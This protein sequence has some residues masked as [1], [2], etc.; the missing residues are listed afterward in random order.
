MI[1]S[2]LKRGDV[3]INS[4]N[5]LGVIMNKYK[6]VYQVLN[7]SGNIYYVKIDYVKS[8]F[9]KTKTTLEKFFIK[10]VKRGNDFHKMKK[11]ASS[12]YINLENII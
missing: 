3:I 8:K 6:K 11:Y 10:S 4:R 7:I 5:T 1:E 9:K 2:E 12:F